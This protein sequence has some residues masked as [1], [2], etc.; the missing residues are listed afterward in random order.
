[1]NKKIFIT[2]LI[3]LFAAFC[4]VG[5]KKDNKTEEE[6][7]K[8][9]IRLTDYE[10]TEGDSTSL[11]YSIDNK[12]DDTKVIIE[13]DD[14]TIINVSDDTI[15]AL[16]AGNA[17]IT[18][19]LEND[20]DNKFEIHVVVN[21]K[22]VDKP[23]IRIKN[24][25]E[26]LAL[27]EDYNVEAEISDKSS[28]TWK[29]EDESIA[30]ITSKGTLTGLKEGTTK[31]IAASKN[32]PEVKDEMEVTFAFDVWT[33]IDSIQNA[34]V[35][36][37]NVK[38]Y[39]ATEP[40]Q[41]VLGSVCDYFFSDINIIEAYGP[42][43]NNKYTG[44]VATEA[45]M[46]ID[47]KGY[48]RPGI[49]LEEL[50]YIVYHDT[51]NVSENADA[52]MHNTYMYGDYNKTSRARSWHY[53][54]DE[55]CVYH[56]VPDN[57]VTWQGDSYEAYA[58]S[59]GIE[60]CVN[61]GS[62]LYR[63]WQRMGKLVAKLL[64]EYGLDVS[65]VKQHYDFNEK[66]CPKTLR[67]NGLWET[68][69]DMIK[70][71]LI[72]LQYLSD[73]TLE[74]KS[75]T[76][77][78]LDDTGKVIGQDKD[79][80]NLCYQITVTDKNGNKES[81]IYHSTL[82]GSGESLSPSPSNATLKLAY[83]FDEKAIAAGTDYDKVS[84][85]LEEYNALDYEV[86]RN[87]ATYD[88]LK[89]LEKA[90]LD[91]YAVDS[92]L[93]INKV[94]VITSDF[95]D[96]KAYSYI[97]LKNISTST[98]T[99][100]GTL[101]I[102]GAKNI[103]VALDNVRIGVGQTYLVAFG[104]VVNNGGKY[105]DFIVPNVVV[106][107]TLP[108]TDFSIKLSD[109]EKTFDVLGLDNA[110]EKEGTCAKFAEVGHAV[111][112]KQALDT[113]D[114]ARDFGSVKTIEPTNA[115]YIPDTV[116]DFDYRVLSLKGNVDLSKEAELNELVA[117]YDEFNDE[118]KQIASTKTLLDEL[119]IEL[120]GIKNPDLAVVKKAILKIPAQIVDDYQFPKQDGLSYVY[121]DAS[122][123]TIFDIETGVYTQVIHE[124]TPVTFTASYGS[125]SEDFTVNF[126]ICDENDLIVYCTATK[127]PSK[128]ITSEGFGTYEDQ[129]SSV[130]FG[131][132]AV[133]VDNKVFFIGTNCLIELDDSNGT[134][135]T[136]AQLR[137]YGLSGAG[138]INNS[139]FVG[140][141]PAEYKGT[142]IL[143]HNNSNSTLT[144]DLTDTYGRA[145]AGSYGYAKCFFGLNENGVMVVKDIVQ[146]T[147]EN[148]KTDNYQVEFAPGDYIWCPHTYE[149]NANGGTWFMF[150]G[151]SA[152][153]GMLEENT[154]LEII[155][156]KLDN[157]D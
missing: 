33:F 144:F 58:K 127:Q 41:I 97:E 154:Q 101:K 14:N 59:I 142:G 12:K 129:A 76:P 117:I 26:T 95:S 108:E 84:A 116:F 67:N 96:S 135:L 44:Q 75:Y 77:K 60:T 39:G 37:Q 139:G 3:V 52:K 114:N 6:K 22:P 20:K 145:N 106:N 134:A 66:D 121:K 13:I 69:Y 133:R 107:D 83:E 53:T 81:K 104:S 89:D 74:F 115:K 99:F 64:D 68:A 141:K 15:S 25:V 55:N 120:E 98:V 143:Y 152:A 17:V 29:V 23:T 102:S 5:C 103:E 19:Y 40:T 56:N 78:Y 24:K 86:K 153:G 146:H 148:F 140:G 147:G 7:A 34:N 43:S 122:Q 80:I 149:T 54:V 123:S 45:I 131:G 73:Y 51:A 125:Y 93:V 28:I 30:T 87:V 57:E 94:F 65:A 119:V 90:Y 91:T 88:Y 1:M 4:L 36:V 70:V 48:T 151:P 109:N 71:E 62:D 136:R 42:I 46:E 113:N 92:S 126:G 8:I 9:Q 124:Y 31:V 111:Q 2:L 16:K 47:E 38:S 157:K 49:Y 11:F 130:G 61:Y 32:F 118:E 50:K 155:Y 35:L 27:F 18:I 150:P 105:Y 128:G 137:P 10:L 21:E 63:T 138:D 112:R 79:N 72:A 82:A 132:V 156:Y 110:S 100:T 85:L